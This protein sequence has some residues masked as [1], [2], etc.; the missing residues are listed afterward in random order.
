MSIQVL[1]MKSVE[2]EFPFMQYF[3]NSYEK[4]YIITELLILSKIFKNCGKG[5]LINKDKI[6]FYKTY[7]PNMENMINKTKRKILLLFYCE[8]SYKQ[9]YIDEFTNN[10]FDLLERDVFENNKLKNNITKTIND[11]FEIYKNIKNKDEIYGEYV[12]NIMKNSIEELSDG[13]GLLA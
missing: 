11:L 7:I 13:E 6:Y 9:K 1:L 4:S 8:S 3:P 12:T 2:E 5:C 10:I